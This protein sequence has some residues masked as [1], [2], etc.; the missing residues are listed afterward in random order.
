MEF[1]T[2]LQ[3]LLAAKDREFSSDPGFVKLR[4]FYAEMKRLGIAQKQE[5][6]LPPLDTVGRRLSI[7]QSNAPQSRSRSGASSIKPS[8]EEAILR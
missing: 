3:S 6:S 8:V 1:A 7:P 5:Y 4:D 2:E